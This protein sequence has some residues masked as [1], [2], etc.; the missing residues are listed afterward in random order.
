MGV[1]AAVFV[2]TDFVGADRVPIHDRLYLLIATVSAM[3]RSARRRFARKAFGMG[4]W[5]SAMEEPGDEPFDVFAILRVL[6]ETLRDQDLRDLADGL[7]ADFPIDERAYEPLQ[8]LSWDMI[9]EMR[10]AGITIG[11]HTRSHVILPHEAI[12]R[13]ADEV[14][15]SRRTLETKLGTP[16]RHFAYPDGRFDAT[17]ARVVAASGFR[18][19]YT[20]CRHRDARYPLLSIP[21]KVMWENSCLDDR[22]LFSPEI[23]ECHSRWI[24]DL[25]SI[26]RQDHRGPAAR[27]VR[28]DRGDRTDP[29]PHEGPAWSRP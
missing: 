26:C 25:L 1:P 2:V 13:V 14:Y 12:E 22:R 28:A 8:S 15:A 29:V 27:R 4:V 10:R 7:E 9:A 16:V 21:R 24:F 19:A 18:Y 20:T 5:F 17:T 3:G 6:L 23:M 11:S